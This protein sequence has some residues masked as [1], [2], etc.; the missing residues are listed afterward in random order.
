[1]TIKPYPEE[2]KCQSCHYARGISNNSEKISCRYGKPNLNAPYW[3]E[4][5]KHAWCGKYHYNEN[6]KPTYKE[7]TYNTRTAPTCHSGHIE[8][9]AEK[10]SI[11]RKRIKDKYPEAIFPDEQSVIG[12]DLS[13]GPSDPWG[14]SR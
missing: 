14:W 13:K 7:I 10:E 1:M 3:P 6:F 5:D 8:T 12:I 9:F 11:V 2:E 4:I